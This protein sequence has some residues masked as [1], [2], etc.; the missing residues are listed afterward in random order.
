[1]KGLRRGKR[2]FFMTLLAA[3]AP[4]AGCNRTPESARQPITMPEGPLQQAIASGA[5]Y[6]VNACGPD[7]QFVY[8]IH[9]DPAVEAKPKYNIVRHAGAIYALGMIDQYQPNP[10]VREVMVRAAEWMK[11]TSMHLAP[12]EAGLLAIWSM[13]EIEGTDDAAEVKLGGTA[14][15]LVALLSVERISPGA[16]SIEQ[17]RGLGRFLVFMQRE[18]G[19]YYSKYSPE[20]GGRDGQWQ[21][22]YYPGEAALGLVMLNQLDP[23]PVWQ[24]AAIKTLLY[25]ADQRRGFVTVEADHW[26][27]L[28]TARLFDQAPEAMTPQQREIIMHHAIQVCRSILIGRPHCAPNAEAE[29]SLTF[30]S[31]TCP[32]ATRLEGLIA[33]L[34]FLPDEQA[35]LRKEIRLAV[36]EGIGFLKRSQIDSGPH[37]GG[38]PREALARKPD[39]TFW[40]V[41]DRSGEIRIDYVQH[42]VSAMIQY[43]LLARD[44]PSQPADDSLA[45]SN[46][47]S[48]A[49]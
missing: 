8:R 39:G 23:S 19:S 48:S 11:E 2:L 29:G 49:R 28:A 24:E 40:F 6:M 33:A 46:E 12:N 32:T 41:D 35:E 22:L 9:L 14:L 13:P 3:F 17:L 27:L 5:E 25:L 31:R 18:D 7:G 20:S 10:A 42:A 15:G 4:I 47:A 43:D 26:A 16:T 38:V 45:I 36:D 44:C 37:R 34:E 30:N 1:M 21:S